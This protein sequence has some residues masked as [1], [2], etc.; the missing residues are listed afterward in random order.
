MELLGILNKVV[1][2]REII[3]VKRGKSNKVVVKKRKY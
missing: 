2:K 1:V 3:L